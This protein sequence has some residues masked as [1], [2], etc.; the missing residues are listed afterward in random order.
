[1]ASEPDPIQFHDRAELRSPML[2][3][4]FRGWNDA[5]DAASFAAEHLVRTWGGKKLASLD[6]E[7][8]FDFQ[9]VRPQV[10]LIDGVTRAISWPANEFYAATLE[11]ASHDALILIGTEP[12]TRWRRFSSLI[13]EVA[14][15]HDVGMVIS[16]GSLLA[17][18]PHSRPVPITGTAADPELIES[19]GLRRSRYEGPTGIVGVLHSAFADAGVGSA[20][21]WA[22]VP[23]YLAITPNPKAALA[24]VDKASELVGFDADTSSLQRATA[25]YERRVEELVS[26]D[27]DVQE[28]VRLLEQRMDENRAAIDEAE[29]P[30]GEAL[31][32]ELERF[33]RERND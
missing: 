24:L 17:D 1:M 23:H 12:N 29:I 9:A 10:H 33:L 13:L 2:I 6:P 18:V 8:F 16:L 5:G 31:A 27:D 19:L 25:G 11:G 32:Q 3:A 26:S 30:S 4:A 15:S 14:A 21:L 28:Y 22:A 20:S 7:E